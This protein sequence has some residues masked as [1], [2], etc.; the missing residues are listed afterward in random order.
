M[1]VAITVIVLVAL[2]VDEARGACSK[3]KIDFALE[4]SSTYFGEEWIEDVKLI[5]IVFHLF[6]ET[7]KDQRTRRGRM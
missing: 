1:K 4:V 5:K 3:E 2:F 7:W 6:S